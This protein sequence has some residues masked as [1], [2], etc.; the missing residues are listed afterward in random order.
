[1]SRVGPLSVQCPV[2][3][4]PIGVPCD[5]HGTVCANRIARAF[6]MQFG[7]ESSFDDQRPVAPKPPGKN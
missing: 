7:A 5:A 2:H 1:M 3:G 4:S 6:A